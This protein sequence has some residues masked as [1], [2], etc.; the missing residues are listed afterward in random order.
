MRSI[1]DS[2]LLT[3]ENPGAADDYWLEMEV[4]P[5]TAPPAVK[6]QS[7]RIAVNGEMVRSFDPLPRGRV[8]CAVPGR[9]LKAIGKVEIR[10]WPVVR[11][12]N[13]RFRPVT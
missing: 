4:I 11:R 1:G 5:Y 8:G 7:L 3:I 13:V 6:S 12:P 9:L 2:S 10:M